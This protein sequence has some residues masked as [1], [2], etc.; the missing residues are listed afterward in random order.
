[1]VRPGDFSFLD[2]FDL[3]S[4]NPTIAGDEL[5]LHHV[6]VRDKDTQQERVVD[7][8]FQWFNNSQSLG[9]MGAQTVA[10]N[11]SL[12]SLAMAARAW[13]TGLPSGVLGWLAG[14]VQEARAQPMMGGPGGMGGMMGAFE[15]PAAGEPAAGIG[16][17]RGWT[18][19]T[20]SGASITGV[21]LT[22]DG[23]PMGTIPCCSQRP[24]VGQAFPTDPSAGNSG[25]GMIFNNGLLS[26]GPHVL[27]VGMGDSMGGH[28]QLEHSITVVRPGGFSFLDQFD[29]SGATATLDGQDVVLSGIHIRDKDSQQQKVIGARFRWSED[30]QSLVMV[31]ADG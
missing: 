29:L 30:S 13:L 31:A 10:A 7:A 6:M 20:Q 3:S 22:I 25:W 9:M 23:T 11:S 27:S 8:S 1:V 16:I 4:A 18:F 17:I 21:Q 15:S 28:M 14:S 2:M 26:A 24:D 5:T 12:R 19:S